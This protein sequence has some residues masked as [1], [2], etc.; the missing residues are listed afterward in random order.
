MIY[1][2]SSP[3]L[4]GE[5]I[6]A[7]VPLE[8]LFVNL[9][10]VISGAEA[11]PIPA[12]AVLL[13]IAVTLDSAQV[14]IR[15]GAYLR[16]NGESGGG[17]VLR[18]VIYTAGGTLVAASRPVSIDQDETEQWVSFFFP[19]PVAT[20]LPAGDYRFGIHSGVTD[21]GAM[22]FVAAEGGDRTAF[23]P[24]LFTDGAPQI[25]SGGVD[26][27]FPMLVF[28]ETLDPVIVPGGVGDDY[29]ATLPFG[30]AQRV[31]RSA[32]PIASSLVSALAGWYGTSFDPTAGANAIVRS[33]G[34]LADLVGERVL[35]TS[36][37]T[38]QDRSV[39]VF[40]HDER[41]FPDEDAGEDL[42]LTARAFLEIAS[43][44]LNDLAVDVVVLG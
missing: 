2:L 15:L 1:G 35:V 24:H 14:V 18:G 32:A 34:P 40:V 13:D 19:D 11:V 44:P 6:E 21:E 30:L 7:G 33:D 39:A 3:I 5:P 36:R 29:L 20:F 27:G 22:F 41:L 4:S 26:T 28:L 43:Q 31:F 9:E 37:G 25:V 16:G 42:M 23:A 38:V 12:H 8:D 17:Q 10:L